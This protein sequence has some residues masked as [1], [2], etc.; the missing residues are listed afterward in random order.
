MDFVNI[1]LLRRQ[2]PGDRTPLS[3]NEQVLIL[4]YSYALAFAVLQNLEGGAE[5]IAKIERRK[6]QREAILPKQRFQLGNL[7]LD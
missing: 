6:I 7:Q 5:K 1:K 4:L 3:T 2:D